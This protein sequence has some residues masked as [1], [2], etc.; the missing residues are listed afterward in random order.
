MKNIYGIV[1]IVIAVMACDISKYAGKDQ[2]ENTNTSKP[3][4]VAENRA[5]ESPKPEA[6]PVGPSLSSVLKK[7]AGKYAYE[8]KLFDNAE[9]SSRLKKLLGK[10]YSAMRSHWNVET[11]IEIMNGIF[12]ASAC[13]AHNCGSNNYYLFVD[14][15]GDNINV[16]HVEDEKPTTYYEKG[17]IQLP[18]EFSEG[19]PTK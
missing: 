19:I 13:E 15:D 7:M 14:L 18:S 17:R 1:A 4:P 10:D 6:S 16:I 11:P 12:K 8:A 9:L 5:K 2:G 3:T